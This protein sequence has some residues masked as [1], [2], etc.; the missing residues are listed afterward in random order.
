MNI[1]GKLSGEGSGGF[2][3]PCNVAFKYQGISLF[4]IVSFYQNLCKE[5]H[6]N[7]PRTFLCGEK[8]GE[9]LAVIVFTVWG[10]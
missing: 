9:S 5:R 2:G 3:L 8:E 6:Q 7:D 10:F 1:P 4:K